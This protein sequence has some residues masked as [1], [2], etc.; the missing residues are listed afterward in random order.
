[1]CSY[2]QSLEDLR[3]FTCDEGEQGLIGLK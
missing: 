1:M 3:K 2:L